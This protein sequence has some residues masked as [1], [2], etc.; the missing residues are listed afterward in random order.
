MVKM[1]LYDAANNHK[2]VLDDA[3]KQWAISNGQ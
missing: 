2:K 1:R 3:N